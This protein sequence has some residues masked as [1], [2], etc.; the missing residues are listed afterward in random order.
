MRA[1]LQGFKAVDV[2][3]VTVSLGQ[4]TEISLKMEVGGLTETVQVTSSAAVV[5]TAFDHDRRGALERAVRE[6]SRSAAA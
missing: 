3:G 1:E 4:T 6:D 5:D 2:K